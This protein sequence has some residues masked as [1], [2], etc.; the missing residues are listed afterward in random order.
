MAKAKQATRTNARKPARTPLV[1]EHDDDDDDDEGTELETGLDVDED[2]A[3]QEADV[4]AELRG[5]GADNEH[6]FTVSRISSKPGEQQGYCATYNA[7]DLSLDNIRDQFGGGKYRI[8]VTDSAGKYVTMRTVEI[9]SLPKPTAAPAQQQAASPDLQGMVTALAAALKP[10]GGGM[11]IQALM[12]AMMNNQAEM[13][14]AIATGRPQES[15]KLTDILTL[16]NASNKG[17]GASDAVATLLQGVKLGKE[18]A[19]GET[20][21]LDVAREGL[22]VL[23]TLITREQDT[24]ATPAQLAAPA[25]TSA[26]NGAASTPK[27]NNAGDP[28]FQKLQ[29][30]RAQIAGLVNQA[31]RGKDPELYAEVLIDNLPGFFTADEIMAKLQEPNAVEQLAM[32]DGRVRQHAEWFEHFRQAAIELLTP[33]DTQP[34]LPGGPTVEA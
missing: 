32:L 8:R 28:M 15:L 33:E 24:T 29:W 4:L 21:M 27:P 34:P 10:Q 11:D 13:L 26:G 17:G 7:G 23:S 5:L 12:L 14:K 18:F 22:G 9:V 25:R 3:H 6:R 2:A 31:A 16:M 19:G 20:G 30:L 1:I